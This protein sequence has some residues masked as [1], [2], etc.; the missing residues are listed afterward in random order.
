MSKRRLNLKRAAA[1]LAKE[2]KRQQQMNNIEG[3]P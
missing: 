1:K 2:K 3:H